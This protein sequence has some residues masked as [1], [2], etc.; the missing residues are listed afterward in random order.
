MLKAIAGAATRPDI[1][2]FGA[3]GQSSQRDQ[4]AGG[5]SMP[6]PSIID[7]DLS[8]CKTWPCVT[9]T[10]I[11]LGAGQTLHGGLCLQRQA[12]IAGPQFAGRRQLML[13][14]PR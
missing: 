13:C 12:W 2:H 6:M 3:E 5:K 10:P 9:L 1:L 14:A 11:A 4:R 8:G 7:I